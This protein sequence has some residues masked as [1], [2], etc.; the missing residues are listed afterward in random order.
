MSILRK[1]IYVFNV[2]PIKN[3]MSFFKEIEQQKITKFVWKP[4]RP[5]IPKAI[6]RKKNKARGITPP[7]F[8]LYYTATITKAVMWF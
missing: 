2:I 8:K 1:A 6:L 5:Q 3:P 4:K 7:D